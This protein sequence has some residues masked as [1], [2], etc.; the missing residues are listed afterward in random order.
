LTADGRYYF[1]RG[2]RLTPYL[3]A[4]LGGAIYGN[5]WGA[6]AGGLALSLGVG[7]EYQIT[8]QTVVTLQPTYQ[9]V[10]FRHF[11]DSTGQHRAEGPLGFGVAHW[12]AV[13][14]VIEA[15]DPLSR[16]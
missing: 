7:L 13:Q 16:W 2:D 15:R 8:A 11:V 3:H 12:L 10:V 4:G 5:E 6:S 1:D 9:P 14:V